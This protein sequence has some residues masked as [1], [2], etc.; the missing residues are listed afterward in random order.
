MTSSTDPVERDAADASG[1]ADYDDFAAAYAQQNDHGLF[2]AW[3]ERPEMLRLAGDVE[4]QRVLD[5]GCGHGPLFDALQARGA[6]V[7]GFDLS[8]AMVALAHDRLGDDADVRVADLAAPLPYADDEFDLV[9]ISLALHY[10]KD[11]APSLRELRRVLRPGGR[12]L[13]AII[14]PFVYAFC[15]PDE[16]YFALTQYSENYDFDGAKA[17]MTYWHRPLQDVMDAFLGAGLAITSVTEPEASPDTPTE[18][19]PNGKRRFISFLFFA[20]ESP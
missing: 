17:V 4:G 16:E 14:H 5:A 13:V 10:V 2:N 20:L 1:S 8:P 6:T 12:I 11:W 15:Y 9:V 18:L 7:S 3:Y 19:L